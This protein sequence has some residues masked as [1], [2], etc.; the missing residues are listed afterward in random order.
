LS[1]TCDRSVVFSGYS[2]FLH[3]D[4]TEIVLKVLLNTITLTPKCD[5][6]QQAYSLYKVYVYQDGICVDITK[7][8]A[9][10]ET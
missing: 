7:L 5:Q 4:I 9:L 3:H 1:V 6:L 2:G 8:S 10:I